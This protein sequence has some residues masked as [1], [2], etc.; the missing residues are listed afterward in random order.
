MESFD[1]NEEKILFWNDEGDYGCFSNFSIYPLMYDGVLWPTSE[2]AYQAC[3]FSDEKTKDEIMKASNPMDAFNI[4]RDVKNILKKDWYEIRI[5]V[6]E[7]IVREKIKQYPIIYNKLIETK[8]RE[9][10]EASP[11][12]SFWGWGPDKN[13]ENHMGKI[14]M[15]LRAEILN[16]KHIIIFSHGFGTRKD[17]RGLLTD[18]A[19]VFPEA[20]SILF[21]YNDIDEEKNILTA[22]LLSEQARLLNDVIEKARFRNKNVD[23]DIVGHS[24]GC[25]VV[26]LAKPTGIRKTIF[27]APSL[28]T[29]IE[30]TINMFKDRP[31]TEINLLGVSKLVRMDGSLTLVPGEFW[32]ERKNANPIPIYNELSF[33]TELVIINA[34]Q[35]EILGHTK[36]KGLDGRIKIFE[37]DGNHQFSGDAR[38]VLLDKIKTFLDK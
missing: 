15:K 2:H 27:I 38:L 23:I 30:H 21:D 3:K 7:K 26:G 9:I 16:K 10:V 5:K 11:I 4:G 14:W 18:I 6:M 37:I 19:K 20:E 29:D 35:D 17:D 32:V 8:D 22:R 31:G 33:N 12:D 36:T 25:L 24:Q 13:G 1:K 34:K 28:D